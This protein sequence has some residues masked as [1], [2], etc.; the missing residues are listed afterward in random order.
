MH[1]IYSIYKGIGLL[2]KL[3]IE[4]ALISVHEDFINLL[5]VL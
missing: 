1:Q 3:Y 4:I 5:H 2:K